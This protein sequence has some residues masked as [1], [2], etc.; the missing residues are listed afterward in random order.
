MVDSDESDQDSGDE[1]NGDIV[2]FTRGFMRTENGNLIIDID[3][4]D[5]GIQDNGM[6][7]TEERDAADIFEDDIEGSIVI[8]G[9]E[10][11]DDWANEF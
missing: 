4:E 1:G 5:E 7:D 6:I 8:L 9:R 10:E 2:E 3:E 11:L